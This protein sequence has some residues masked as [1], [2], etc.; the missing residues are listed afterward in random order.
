MYTQFIHYKNPNVSPVRDVCEEDEEMQEI[1]EG[2]PITTLMTIDDM[3]REEMQS[4]SVTEPSP[5][6]ESSKEAKI[7]EPKGRGP[8]QPYNK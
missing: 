4:P 5:A 8:R 6:P 3:E 2:G 7:E 1:D